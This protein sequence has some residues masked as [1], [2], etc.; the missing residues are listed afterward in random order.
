MYFEQDLERPQGRNLR[1]SQ[2]EA[3]KAFILY[4]FKINE[5]GVQYHNLMSL[6]E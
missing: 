4:G 5:Y 6:W 3:M 2:S 1:L